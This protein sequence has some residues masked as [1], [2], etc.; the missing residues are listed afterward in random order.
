MCVFLRGE[1]R[2]EVACLV[3][4]GVCRAHGPLS[5]QF[6]GVLF[7]SGWT[8]GAGLARA[9]VESNNLPSGWM[10]IIVAIDLSFGTDD[11]L[12]WRSVRVIILLNLLIVSLVQGRKDV[13]V[14]RTAES[15]EHSTVPFLLTNQVL[16]RS[17]YF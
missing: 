13:M 3:T 16:E 6:R 10:Q 17:Q 14:D 7:R 11:Q 5:L 8:R 2:V 12:L 1:D 15:V 9:V 4:S